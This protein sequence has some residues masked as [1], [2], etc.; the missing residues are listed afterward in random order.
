MKRQRMKEAGVKVKKR[1]SGGRKRERE[2][3]EIVDGREVEKKKTKPR[4]E[5]ENKERK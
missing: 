3:G 4:K 1:E 5:G 2:D